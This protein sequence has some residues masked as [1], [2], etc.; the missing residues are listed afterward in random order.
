MDGIAEEN[1]EFKAQSAVKAEQEAHKC[2]ICG[3]PDHNA[4]G[5]EAR[6][7]LGK[8]AGQIKEALKDR[9]EKEAAEA[10]GDI[11]D[12]IL[13]SREATVSALEDIVEQLKILNGAILR[14]AASNTA[15][16]TMLCNT[17]GSK[18]PA[19]NLN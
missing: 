10:A 12:K 6:A 15:T 3:S 13:E 2:S 1:I 4:C 7:T 11:I 17:F 14:M 8:E 19:Q 18:K 9:K 16:I 5:C